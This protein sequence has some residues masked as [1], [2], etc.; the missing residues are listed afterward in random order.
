MNR[1]FPDGRP[2]PPQTEASPEFTRL[3]VM[4]VLTAVILGFACGVV[5]VA[6]QLLRHYFFQ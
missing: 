1:R 3:F 4:A 5:W 6:Y 2:R